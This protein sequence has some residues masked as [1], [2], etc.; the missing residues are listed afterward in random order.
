MI[1]KENYKNYKQSN[2]I[3]TTFD[4]IGSAS[5]STD[6]VFEKI[7]N[8]LTIET[9]TKHD[10]Q[11]IVYVCSI[12]GLENEPK[13]IIKHHSFD[14]TITIMDASNNQAREIYLISSFISI[15]SMAQ[16]LYNIVYRGY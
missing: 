4:S 5:I 6:K 11:I 2:K 14:N 16:N 3:L 15:K 12:S 13:I 7:S 8:N 10:A 1:G 9:I